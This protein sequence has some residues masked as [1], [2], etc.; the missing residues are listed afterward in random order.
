M[1]TQEIKLYEEPAAVVHPAPQKATE[2]VV[3]E[4]LHLAMLF[5]ITLGTRFY[6]RE[7]GGSTIEVEEIIVDPNL[8]SYY[9]NEPC[10]FVCARVGYQN[11]YK[12]RYS[13]AELTNPN[14]FTMLDKEKTND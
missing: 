9:K 6:D 5:E 7:F 10:M 11:H 2:Q 1:I 8:I 14:R 13:L 3:A 4:Q 12:V